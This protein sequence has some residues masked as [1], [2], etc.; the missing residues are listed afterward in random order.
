MVGTAGALAAGRRVHRQQDGGYRLHTMAAPSWLPGLT[1]A[2]VEALQGRLHT[3]SSLQPLDLDAAG[4]AGCC[5]GAS[6]R[7]QLDYHTVGGVGWRGRRGF[8]GGFAIRGCCCRGV[9]EHPEGNH[10]TP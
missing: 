4:G 10:A 9:Q 2:G 8:K 7:G 3:L 5:G 1:M 6:G